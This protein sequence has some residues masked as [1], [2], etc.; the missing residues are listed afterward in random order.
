[1]VD[2][3]CTLARLWGEGVLFA[4]WL[5]HEH[6]LDDQSWQVTYGLISAR[7]I[8]MHMS[9]YLQRA[10]WGGDFSISSQNWGNFGASKRVLHARGLAP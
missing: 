7:S 3:P 10:G 9:A 8:I 6:A 2:Q 5:T 1:M 4:P